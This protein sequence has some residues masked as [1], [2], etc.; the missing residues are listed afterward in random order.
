MKPPKNGA[1]FLWF[2]STLYGTVNGIIKRTTCQ[3]AKQH[4]LIWLCRRKNE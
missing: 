3:N 1:I 4:A 2:P